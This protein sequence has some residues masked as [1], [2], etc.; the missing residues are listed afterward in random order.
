MWHPIVT[1]DTCGQVHE[2]VR[3]VSEPCSYSL[4]CHGCESVLT[5]TLSGDSLSRRRHDRST[6]ERITVSGFATPQ[7]TRWTEEHGVS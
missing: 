7:R 3:L 5:V 1:C 4:I 6:L 2:C